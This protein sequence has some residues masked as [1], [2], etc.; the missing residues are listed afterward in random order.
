MNFKNAALAAIAVAVFGFTLGPTFTPLAEAHTT[1]GPY[2]T[3][4]WVMS[5]WVN[6]STPTWVK[7]QTLAAHTETTTS[8]VN[9][10]DGRL[11]CGVPYQV[12]VYNN[13]DTTSKLIAGG[14]LYGPN[15]PPES[16]VTWKLVYTTCS[17]ST[18]T[19]TVTATATA[20]K[21][22]TEPGATTTVT[23][24]LPGTT[25]TATATETKTVETPGP[26]TTV[27]QPGATATATETATATTTVAGPTSTVTTTLPGATTTVSGPTTTVT[28]TAPCVVPTKTVTE[29][30][31]TKATQTNQSGIL[32]GTGSS[33]TA[34]MALITAFFIVAGLV[35]M[36]ISQRKKV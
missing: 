12:D 32:A 30:V 29:T 4:A 20:T 25:T 18:P 36:A 2:V 23:H 1:T 14:I 26:T 27:T 28:S 16:L 9:A 33:T 13:N 7:P 3:V 17:T 35:L 11:R 8:N 5:S 6:D 24:T 19:V 21:T 34:W 31:T 10:L 22:V 15:N